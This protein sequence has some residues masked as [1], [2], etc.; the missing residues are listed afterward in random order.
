MPLTRNR[1]FL[2]SN[3]INHIHTSCVEYIPLL[4]GIRMY[5]KN[6]LR[7]KMNNIRGAAYFTKRPPSYILIPCSQ[8]THPPS[9]VVQTPCPINCVNLEGQKFFIGEHV[10]VVDTL[11]SDPLRRQVPLRTLDKPLPM[12]Q[13]RI[14]REIPRSNLYS[15]RLRLYLSRTDYNLLAQDYRLRTRTPA[16]APGILGTPNDL[17]QTSLV[18]R[19][20]IQIRLPFRMDKFMRLTSDGTP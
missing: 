2:A 20:T 13:A 15:G 11:H 18:H 17:C 6:G 9:T 19:E 16:T 8:T 1:I 4:L 3:L 14:S 10:I 5:Q 12:E 7:L